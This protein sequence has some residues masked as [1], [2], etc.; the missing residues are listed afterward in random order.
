MGITSYAQNYEDVILWRSLGHIQNG[1]YIDIGAQESRKDSVSWAFYEKGWRGVHVEPSPHYANLLRQDRPGELVIQ[2]AITEKPGMLRFFEFPETGL[3]TGSAEIASTHQ[4]NGFAV[5][6]TIV[7]AITLDNLFTEVAQGEIHWLKI[8]VEGFEKEVLSSWQTSECRPW[9]VVIES[10]IPCTQTEIY[11]EW[12]SVI[13]EKGYK[14]VYFDGLNRFYLSNDHLEFEKNFNHGP[15]VFDEYKIPSI[16]HLQEHRPEPANNI[17]GESARDQALAALIQN[18]PEAIRPA[19]ESDKNTILH[20]ISVVYGDIATLRSRHDSLHALVQE[21]RSTLNEANAITQTELKQLAAEERER[22]QTRAAQE[23]VLHSEIAAVAA[24]AERD[25]A[26][27]LALLTQGSDR[28]ETLLQ[29]QRETLEAANAQMRERIALEQAMRNEIAAVATREEHERART[30]T[31]LRL[32]LQAQQEVQELVRMQAQQQ[33]AR[34]RTL[35]KS[36]AAI[37][38]Q[39]INIQSEF[40]RKTD[41]IYQNIQI[42][43]ERDRALLES[44]QHEG[45]QASGELRKVNHA[46]SLYAQNLQAMKNAS[47]KKTI[48][49]V[50]GILSIKRNR[51]PSQSENASEW[52]KKIITDKN[53]IIHAIIQDQES[54]MNENSISAASELLELH[55]AQFITAAYEYIFGRLP[56]PDGFSHYLSLIRQ[57]ESRKKILSYLYKSQEFQSLGLQNQEIKTLVRRYRWLSTPVIG[58]FF[59]LMLG[60]FRKNDVNYKIRAIEN[61]LSVLVIQNQQNTDKILRMIEGINISIENLTAQTSSKQSD[62]SSVVQGSNALSME[63]DFNSRIETI[64]QNIRAS[65]I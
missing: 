51:M 7:A 35:H 24:R 56:D 38:E 16:S 39:S 6:E 10:T 18:I 53:K 46:I 4:K 17:I 60:E 27:T 20:H 26:E 9:I 11:A 2:A 41:Q 49:V 14:F 34:E 65:A 40:N 42:Y 63:V 31:L 58:G 64:S 45:L 32:L 5:N 37:H 36:I 33:T 48:D 61:A 29:L 25:H 47:W 43:R 54:D 44:I 62:Q 8:D 59:R 55:D 13:V 12:E 23:R 1:F 22:C 21:T 15:C 28:S 57:G 52:K 50:S 3:S 19:Q 30:E